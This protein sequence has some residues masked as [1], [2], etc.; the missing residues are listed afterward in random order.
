[1]RCSWTLR[2][3]TVKSYKEPFIIFKAQ[4]A[5]VAVEEGRAGQNYDSKRK[6]FQHFDQ[7]RQRYVKKIYQIH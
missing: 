2:H 5:V 6:F 1:M 7:L 4:A 3:S